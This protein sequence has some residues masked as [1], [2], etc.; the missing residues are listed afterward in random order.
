MNETVW[1]DNYREDI[2]SDGEIIKAMVI[3]PCLIQRPIITNGDKAVI[4]RSL[5]NINIIL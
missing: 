1:K 5:E 3:Y 2:L 4:G